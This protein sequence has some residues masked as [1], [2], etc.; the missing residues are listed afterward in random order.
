MKKPILFPKKIS[1]DTLTKSILGVCAFIVIFGGFMANLKALPASNVLSSPQIPI[2][3]YHSVLDD[4]KRISKYVI[5]PNTL[6]SDFE[7]LKKE[8]FTP[9]LSEDL[10][11]FSNEGA[12]LPEKPIIITFDDGYYNNYVYA[13]PLLKEFGFKGVLSIVGEYSAEFSEKDAV[14]NNNYSHVTFDMLKEMSESGLV[15]IACHSYDFHNISERKGILR[16]KGEDK[17]HYKELL[18]ADTLKIEELIS[19]KTGKKPLAYTYPFGAINNDAQEI[20]KNMGFSVTYGCEE[21]LNIVT[22]DK[23]SLLNLKRYNRDGKLSTEE[24]F[25]K[26]LK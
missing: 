17:S 10:I 18:I 4:S 1:K 2:I 11:K 19:I 23:N 12:S 13:F 8:G 24:F 20:I 22:S 26:I 15:E 9:I 3:M 21:G 16:K 7:Y 5:S 14:L 6:K 25:G